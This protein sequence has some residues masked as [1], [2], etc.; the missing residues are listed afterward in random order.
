MGGVCSIRRAFAQHDYGGFSSLSLCLSPRWALAAFV[1]DMITR[2]DSSF[3]SISSF[4]CFS[5]I[6]NSI[7]IFESCFLVFPSSAKSHVLFQSEQFSIT[8]H[9]V[10]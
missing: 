7:F 8:W 4:L 1:K 5:R 3:P 2:L 6:A 9:K 10:G